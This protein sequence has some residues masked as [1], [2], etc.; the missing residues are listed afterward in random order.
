ML[1]YFQ[2]RTPEST[3]SSTLSIEGGLDSEYQG[4]KWGYLV[5][6]GMDGFAGAIS[7]DGKDSGASVCAGYLKMSL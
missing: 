4:V 5:I 3:A 2:K 6:Q 7:T 1:H